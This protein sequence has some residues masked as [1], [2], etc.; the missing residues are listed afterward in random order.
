MIIVYARACSAYNIIL[1]TSLLG[2]AIG[3]S[4]YI[5]KGCN[6]CH[7]LQCLAEVYRISVRGIHQPSDDDAHALPFGIGHLSVAQAHHGTEV[8]SRQC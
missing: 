4:P 3:Q 5:F 6:M 2:A 8:P 7:Q 1:F